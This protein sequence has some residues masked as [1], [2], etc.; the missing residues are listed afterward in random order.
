M[1]AVAHSEAYEAPLQ[2][3][4]EGMILIS[5]AVG[6]RATSLFVAS[7]GMED[8]R[9]VAEMMETR[10]VFSVVF[11]VVVVGGVC[12]I[13]AAPGRSSDREDAYIVTLRMGRKESMFNGCQR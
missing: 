13:V 10:R 9:D 3:P 1:S 8:A 5:W 11:D 7:R 12:G 2:E 4:A 6:S